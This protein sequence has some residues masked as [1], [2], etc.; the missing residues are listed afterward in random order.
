M[1]PYMLTVAAF[2]LAA[3]ALLI[4][5]VVLYVFLRRR[6]RR[7]K[8]MYTTRPITFDMRY[9]VDFVNKIHFLR[10]RKDFPYLQNN[11]LKTFV[12]MFMSEH[13]SLYEFYLHV[14]SFIYLYVF[15]Y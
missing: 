4:G 8:Y 1:A 2:T 9:I 6:K 11:N 12:S 14:L 15:H 3:I 13:P 5:T 7:C 10:F